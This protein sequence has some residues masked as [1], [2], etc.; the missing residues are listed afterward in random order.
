MQ[1]G[2]G[3]WGEDKQTRRRAKKG[4]PQKEEAPRKSSRRGSP[5]GTLQARRSNNRCRYAQGQ[6]KRGPMSS[7]ASGGA[8]EELL[9]PG[10]TH[11]LSTREDMPL[12]EEDG[13]GQ[14]HSLSIPWGSSPCWDTGTS[15]RQHSCR[16]ATPDNQA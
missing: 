4:S 13:H 8:R 6:Q 2:A 15:P 3:T 14:P 16:E 7:P 11:H 1:S 10:K 5:K 9:E 12:E